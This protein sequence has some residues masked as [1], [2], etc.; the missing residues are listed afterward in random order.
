[1][2]FI[3]RYMLD[4]TPCL[5]RHARACT[6]TGVSMKAQEVSGRARTVP[7]VNFNRAQAGNKVDIYK[8]L[9]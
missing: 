6:G 1:M 2:L 5:N 3:N 8:K 9:N 4:E 7:A